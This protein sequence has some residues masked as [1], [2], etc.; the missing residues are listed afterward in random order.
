MKLITSATYQRKI[1]NS[2]KAKSESTRK[3][4]ES[5]SIWAQ[6]TANRQLFHGLK[7]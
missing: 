7:K 1:A 4:G 5:K 2:H 3:A 6:I